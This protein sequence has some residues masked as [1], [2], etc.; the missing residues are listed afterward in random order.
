VQASAWNAASSD[1][2]QR[3]N[4]LDNFWKKYN[5]AMLDKLYL[6]KERERLEQENAAL[7]VGPCPV[8]RTAVCAVVCLVREAHA[9]IVHSLRRR[10]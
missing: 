10:S 9:G 8:V 1:P 5:K 7:Q 2:V 3:W 4:H 6:D